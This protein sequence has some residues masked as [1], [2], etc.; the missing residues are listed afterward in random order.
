MISVLYES[1]SKSATFTKGNIHFYLSGS[2]GYK[3]PS[4][5]NVPLFDSNMSTLLIERENSV[6]DITQ[7]NVYKLQYRRAKR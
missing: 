4:I 7:D 3:S 1:T 2:S 5:N 6:D